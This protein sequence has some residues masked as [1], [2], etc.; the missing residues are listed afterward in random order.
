MGDGSFETVL[1]ADDGIG[2]SCFET[3]AADDGHAVCGV[4]ACSKQEQLFEAAV[5]AEE[6]I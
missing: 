4:A 3:V 5:V 2:G 1:V 6:R